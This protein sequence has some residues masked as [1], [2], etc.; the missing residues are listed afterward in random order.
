MIIPFGW[1][2]FARYTRHRK[3]LPSVAAL[4]HASVKSLP[5]LC[6]MRVRSVIKQQNLFIPVMFI[7]S[8]HRFARG[9]QFMGSLTWQAEQCNIMVVCSLHCGTIQV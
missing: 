7:W 6:L 8:K 1:H 5:S 9:L 4:Y 2:N 3:S